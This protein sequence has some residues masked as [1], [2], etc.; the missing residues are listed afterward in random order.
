MHK[1]AK[2]HKIIL[3]GATGAIGLAIIQ[4]CIEK[5]W[6]AIVIVRP[7]SARNQR[8]PNHENIHVV[9]CDLS[10]IDSLCKLDLCK[11]A[12]Y[13]LHLAWAGTFGEQRNDKAMQQKNVAS[14]I[15]ACHVAKK[16]G[17]EAFLFAGSQAEYG[18]V[19]GALNGQTATKPE[20][21][22][23]RAKLEAGLSTLDVCK[24]NGMRHIYIRILS[25]YGPG[26]GE[27]TMISAAI[28]NLKNG[29]SPQFT[30]GEQLWDYL[31]SEDA[32]KAL[33]LAC[34]N[35]KTG[36]IYCLGSGTVKPLKEYISFIG[37]IVNPEVVLQIGALPYRE[38]QVMYLCADLK[39]LQEDCGFHP[40]VSFEEGIRKT[41]DWIDK[42]GW[43]RT[44]EVH[45]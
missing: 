25:V 26:D 21:E 16:I 32:A 6:E 2:R 29:I 3:T 27:E 28:R 24:K 45:K 22:Y 39:D 17:C 41:Q 1:E 7:E 18:R 36:K 43:D 13:F 42:Y 37:Q 12:E 5:N 10:E 8:I 4:K 40:S 30:P 15:T 31:Y 20:N 9:E 23:G 14:A 19:E 34:Q 44:G 38:N 33:L 11:G 35:G